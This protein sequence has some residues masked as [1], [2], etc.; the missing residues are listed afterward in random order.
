LDSTHNTTLHEAE[1]RALRRAEARAV[2]AMVAMLACLT[3]MALLASGIGPPAGFES[4][5]RIE[6][7]LV[8][9]AGWLWLLRR[10][11]WQWWRIRQDRRAGLAATLT[12]AIHMEQHRGIGLFA[13]SHR[14]IVIERQR[15]PTPWLDPYAFAPGDSV[16]AR[17]APR[18]RVLLSLTALSPIPLV[19]DGPA[20]TPREHSL[21]Q[22]LAR[23][24]PDKVIARQLELTPATV[25]TYNSAL[26]AK[27]GAANRQE[28]VAR[29]REKRLVDIDI[30]V[31]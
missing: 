16:R 18:S 19:Q 26:F 3:G 5:G 2:L 9:L 7:V 25:R 13:P 27:L 21:L 31:N 10:A 1:R 20:L 15:F 23:D 4:R 29:A 14:A 6:L 12:G 28:A 17:I 8:V 22:L 30:D 24:L 11:P